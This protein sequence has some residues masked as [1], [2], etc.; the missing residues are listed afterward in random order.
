MP[1]L[2]P[3]ER[4][5]ILAKMSS[6]RRADNMK[7]I[8]GTTIAILA[9]VSG[10]LASEIPAKTQDHP[11]AIVGATIHPVSGPAIDNGTI[12]FEKGKITAVGANV[13]LPQ[14]AEVVDGKG[15]HVY[16]GF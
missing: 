6:N 12:L 7:T 5:N 3:E 16:P 15:K 10:V 2:P 4:K 8:I 9:A 14:G 1:R 11:I 13:T